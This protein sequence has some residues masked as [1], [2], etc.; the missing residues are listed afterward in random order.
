[1]TKRRKNY[2]DME[3]KD[4]NQ[5]L[6]IKELEEEYKAIKKYKEGALGM[7]GSII[8]IFFGILCIV[9][10]VFSDFEGSI[11]ETMKNAWLIIGIVI[12][13]GG[14]I[15]LIVSIKLYKDSKKYIK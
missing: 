11:S 2:S 8:G 6:D 1:M 9:V 10:S 15:C 3:E 12:I 5:S 7:L 4:N 13:F 14:I